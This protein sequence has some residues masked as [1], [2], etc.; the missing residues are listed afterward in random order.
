MILLKNIY[1]FKGGKKL[2]NKIKYLC[3]KYKPKDKFYRNLKN[4]LCMAWWYYGYNPTTKPPTDQIFRN[5]TELYK[6]YFML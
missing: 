4:Q 6:L 2:L 1:P 5:S 3:F